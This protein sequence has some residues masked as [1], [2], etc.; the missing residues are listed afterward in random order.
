MEKN[1]FSF[2]RRMFR[3]HKTTEQRKNTIENHNNKQREN[4]QIYGSAGSG[5]S[6]HHST[7]LDGVYVEVICAIMILVYHS[8][9]IQ[10]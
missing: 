8:T 6:K 4:E 10:C 2:V 9:M 7:Y 1:V 3:I 5:N